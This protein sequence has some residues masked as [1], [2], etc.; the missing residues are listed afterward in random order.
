[1]S[2]LCLIA[3]PGSSALRGLDPPGARWLAP[4]EAC[5]VETRP[6]GL[7]GL[8]VDVV[9]LDGPPRPKRLLVADMDSTVITVECIDELAGHLGLRD[10]VAAI[11]RRAMNGEVGFE[12]AL[13][14]R[15]ALLEGLP[16]AALLEV[17]RERVRLMPG[18]R[19]LVRTMRALG[20]VT[21]LVSGGFTFFTGR[22]REACGFHLDEANELEV[23]GGRLTGRV[24]PP[25]RGRDAKLAVLER[26]IAEHGIARADTLAVGD[27]ANDLPML[28]AAGLGVAFRAHPRVEAEVAAAIRHGDLTAL[29]YLQGIPRHDFVPA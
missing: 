24:V 4:R 15:V 1:M 27:G 21:A 5:L 2:Q 25:I 6:P 10:E 14:E 7:D 17:W 18:A 29:L 23:R 9:A 13:I 20:A 3:A 19:T 28:Q 16:E 22:V 26:L 8:P 12:G 11:T